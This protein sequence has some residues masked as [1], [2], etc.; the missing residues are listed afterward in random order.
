MTDPKADPVVPAVLV[1][2]HFPSKA[3]HPWPP[4]QKGG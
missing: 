2:M 4:C 3:W 1:T